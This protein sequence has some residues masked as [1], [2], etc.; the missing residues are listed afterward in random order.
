[1]QIF[2]PKETHSAEKRVPLIPSDA[3]RLVEKGCEVIIERGM[4][5]PSR[6]EDE[7]Y[8]KA[9]A[10]VA[11]DRNAALS[12]ADMV[13]RLRKPPTE[14]VALLKPGCI[15]ISYLDPFNEGALV[16]ALATG[17]VTAI[18]MEM[19]PRTTRAQK[20]DA[21]SSQASLAGYVAVIIAAERLAQVFP[22][23]TTPA[24]TLAPAR[25][26]VIGA[27]VAGLQA[28]ATAKRLGARVD[29]F[30]TRPVVAEQVASLG[31]RFV[32]IDLGETEEAAGG[33]AKELTAEQQQMQQEAMARVCIQS[34]VVI[35][36]A[37]LFGRPAPRIITRDVV[38]QMKPGSVI[39]DLA[40]ETGG[41]VEGSEVDQEVEIGGVRIV[42]L[43]NLPGRVAVHASQMYSANISALV[44]EIWDAEQKAPDLDL[45]NEILQGC[46][47]THAGAIVNQMLLDIM[48]RKS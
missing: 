38:E 21:L 35:T 9:G 16:E 40:V 43:A 11:D 25:V 8:E 7:A 24:G 46:V 34:D 36:T 42:G 17:Q 47:V 1:V 37:Q 41:N 19:M 2:V 39:V 23:M 31:A 15:H 14:E 32:Q 10:A 28:I 45:E 44:E 3:A 18:S 27:G 48:S 33:Y 20:M 29:A 30:D 5:V 12:A 4:G 13:L 6:H 22:M 26:F